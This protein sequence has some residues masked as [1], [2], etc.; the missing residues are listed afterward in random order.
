LK[1]SLKLKIET[2]HSSLQNLV[3]YLNMFIEKSTYLCWLFSYFDEQ[4]IHFSLFHAKY[5]LAEI[6][7]RKSEMVSVTSSLTSMSLLTFHQKSVTSSLTD[8]KIRILSFLWILHFVL[9]NDKSKNDVTLI[10]IW[11]GKYF[12]LNLKSRAETFLNDFFGQH[13]N[14]VMSFYYFL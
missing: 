13:K 10:I 7:S 9:R 12:K 14:H 2:I 3:F 11:L 4:Q 6:L 8:L 5:H 1:T